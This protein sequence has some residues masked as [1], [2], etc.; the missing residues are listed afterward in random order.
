MKSLVLFLSLLALCLPRALAQVTSPAALTGL[1]SG[2]SDSLVRVEI[3]P[4][5]A[6]G[7]EP[8][9]YGWAR[10][11]PNCGNFHGNEAVE[12]LKEKRPLSWV[13]LLVAPDEVVVMDPLLDATFVESWHVSKGGSQ[14][15]ASLSGISLSR[16]AIRL[17]LA[18]P[19]A[20]A[21]P[22]TRFAESGDPV[23][24]LTSSEESANWAYA[25]QSVGGGLLFS[26]DGQ[27]QLSCPAGALVVD[28]KGQALGFSTSEGLDSGG[29]WRLH[30]SS[31]DW[32]G[33]E[34]Y[35]SLM[36][37]LSE[38]VNRSILSARVHLRAL[39]VKKGRNGM[40]MEE[41]QDPTQAAVPALV[42]SPTRVMV[43]VDLAPRLTARL[44]SVELVSEGHP[45]PAKFLASSSQYGVILVEPQ[46]PLRDAITL[47]RT[48]WS[49][50]VGSLLPS[51]HL[52]F[53]ANGSGG[54]FEHRRVSTLKHG[55]MGM[56]VPELSTNDEAPFLF[57]HKGAL[58]GF[59]VGGRSGTQRNRWES[60]SERFYLHASA[61][62]PYLG[63]LVALSDPNNVPANPQESRRKPWLGIGLQMMDEELARSSGT[64]ELIRKGEPGALVT[65]VYP[66]SPA[67]R[68]K[69]EIG[70]VVLRVHPA[71]A[72][73]PLKIELEGVPF[74]D[75]SFP[76]DKY[77]QLPE[78][79]YDQ[80]PEPW[81]SADGRLMDALKD[82]GFGKSCTLE[83]IRA[84]HLCS[85]EFTIESGPA[86]YEAMIQ[87]SFP[88][89]GLGLKE[90]SYDT[91]HYLQLDSN[92]PGLI[93]ASV[94]PGSLASVAGIKPYE[95]LVSANE[96][97]L[98]SIADLKAVLNTQTHINLVIRRLHETRIVAIDVKK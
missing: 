21:K 20:G 17:H 10:R 52:T 54:R 87:E 91:R 6:E 95:V 65:H 13:G 78:A 79:Y 28:A 97:P 73:L 61:L 80:I 48:P 84:G 29:A 36:K 49:G 82:I 74:A 63:D 12:A 62:T 16:S 8:H 43:L 67:A 90:L 75:G 9:T 55:F 60:N 71:G 22:I 53:T 85:A 3:T 14:V 72:P 42:L 32:M 56:T 46:T 25:V 38:K 70:D 41:R 19:L 81:Q 5:T 77:D 66:D 96:K 93:A 23:R 35:Q 92:A 26:E 7:H 57:D 33:I 89:I 98:Q 44:E 45:V 47:S 24:A 31:W 27:W 11:C 18:N 86:D 88:A 94:Q 15:E 4:R 68:M 76:W 59:P 50:L 83:Y 39:P 64:L 51:V 37:E 69:L 58:V 40:D 2:F 1:P 34:A 30:P